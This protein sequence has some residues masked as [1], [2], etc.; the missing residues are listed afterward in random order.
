MPTAQK[1]LVVNGHAATPDTPASYYYGEDAD[2][3][4]PALEEV[5]E[6]LKRVGSI[7][8]AAHRIA[9][10]V[11]H[12]ATE[13]KQMIG[14]IDNF[15]LM[16]QDVTDFNPVCTTGGGGTYDVDAHLLR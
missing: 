1:R 12:E 7:G 5:G 13:R 16:L 6:R 2:M 11:A 8:E 14:G 4:P 15:W 10:F 3:Q 9:D